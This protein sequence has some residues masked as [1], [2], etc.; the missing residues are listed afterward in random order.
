MYLR[1]MPMACSL[2]IFLPA[3]KLGR[4]NLF[5]FSQ[6]SCGDNKRISFINKF[7]FHPALSSLIPPKL[8]AKEV[9][10]LPKMSIED[11]TGK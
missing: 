1:K 8:V 4:L 7:L 5:R 9:R 11:T 3:S 6:L 2:E 10:L